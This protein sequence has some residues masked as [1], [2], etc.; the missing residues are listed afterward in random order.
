MEYD[1]V[2]KVKIEAKNL[3][4]LRYILVE[5]YSANDMDDVSI[6]NKA[7]IKKSLVPK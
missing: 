5:T 1:I 3:D 6:T 2:M 4:E 7:G